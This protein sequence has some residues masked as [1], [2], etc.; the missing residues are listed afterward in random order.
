MV[1]RKASAAQH[2]LK[3]LG[4]LRNSFR[5]LLLQNPN[6][7]GNIEGSKFKAVFPLQANKT[8]E[9]LG[10]VGY[11][12]QTERLEAVVYVNEPSGYGGGL[13]GPGTV[14]YVRFYAS[15]DNGGSW[16]DLGLGAFNVWDVPKGTEG[17]KRLEYAV[18]LRRAFDRRICFFPQIVLIRA[19]LSWN[20]VP[21]PNTPNHVPVWGDIHNTHVLVEPRRFW[22]L[23]DVLEA[24]SLQLKPEIA[25]IVSEDA[26]LKV[27]PKALS[28]VELQHL[29]KGKDVPLKRFAHAHLAAYQASAGLTASLMQPEAPNFLQTLGI[30][31]QAIDWDDLFN[32]GDGDTSY[33]TLE[34]IGYDPNDDS[35]VGVIRLHRPSGFSGG[36]CTDG[37]RE[38]VTFWADLNANGT[39]ETCLGTASVRVYDIQ[40]IPR[41]GLEVGIHLPANLLRER[42]PCIEGPRIIP[43][44]AILSWATPIPCATPNATPVWGNRLDTLVHVQPGRRIGGLEPLL[45]SVGG[46]P[47]GDID[48]N[49]FAQNAI[50][51]TTGA[52]FNDAPFGGRIN[53]AG[54]IVNGIASTRYR[55]MIRLHSVG[56][57][58]PLSLEPGGITLIVVT[59]GPVTTWTTIHADADGY[60]AYQDFSSSH[61]VEGNILAV[62]QTGALEHG[63]KY[64]LRIDIKDPGNPLVDIESNVVTV[65]IDNTA[66][67]LTLDFTTLAGD[68]AHF[69]EGA[70]FS[71]NFSVTDPHFGGFSFEIL[72]PGPAHGVLPSPAAGASFHL[73]GAIPDPGISTTFTLNTAG[74]DPCGYALVLHATDRTNV[75]SGQTSNYNKD[76]V[77]FCLGN[78]PEG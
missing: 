14:E 36:P 35:L 48:G 10:C 4:N 26:E 28:L 39:F 37:S 1:A 71:G 23:K 40:Q 56:S 29:Y 77:G 33:E 68:C 61:Y 2:N 27:D 6:Y 24:S 22:V 55:P 30:D 13:C 19:I 67:T 25:K 3:T 42:I 11:Q 69:G 44:R 72:P 54:K 8:Y 41:D 66:P 18:T 70:I 17:R 34:C 65:E 63:K 49:G 78:P 73:G 47:V 58:V 59:P 12:P 38:Y 52:Y 60:Y 51:V 75:N 74:M 76:S 57:F 32:V 45:S 53:L 5:A 15:W 62:W 21:P 31:L 43:I 7:F 9:N 46:I 16:T 50:A 64:D 20:A